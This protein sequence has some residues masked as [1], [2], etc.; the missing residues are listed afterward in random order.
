MDEVSAQSASG[1]IEVNAS[2]IGHKAIDFDKKKVRKALQTYARKVQKS[3]RR[4]VAR[5]AVSSAGGMPGRD[6]GA[7]QKS[8]GLKWGSGGFWVR[9]EPKTDAIRATGKVYY[10]AILYFGAPQHGL[11]ARANYMTT[12]LDS[13]RASARAAIRAAMQDALKPR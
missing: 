11:G 9:I 2:I 6:T 1:G 13:E 7:L 5:R 4:L 12:A 8:I 10:P 3:A